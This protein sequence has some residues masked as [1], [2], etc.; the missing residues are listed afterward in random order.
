VKY[1]GEIKSS[2]DLQP[3][4][5]M[6]Q[7]W[8]ELI[9]GPAAPSMLVTPHAVAVHADGVR[10]AVADT[11]SACVHIF[12]LENQQYQRKD[13]VGPHRFQSPTGVAW[14]GDDL[15]VADARVHGLAG[16]SNGRWIGLDQLKRPSGLAFC[17]TNRLLYVADAAAHAIL[18]F[19]RDGRLALQFGGP[20][21][22]AGQFNCPTQL[23]CTQDAVY[24]IDSLNSRVQWMGLD[25][26]PM[27]AFGRP[28]DAAGDLALP[29]GIAIA[30]DG[31]L[32]I[33]DARFENV[34][35]FT[36]EGKLLMALGQEGHGPGEFWLPAGACID[37]RNRLWIA[38]AYNR[39]VQVFQLLP[40][41]L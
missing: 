20:G 4:K 5:S 14:A 28:G 32:W 2:A 39:R 12:N 13:A 16:I 30:S 35:A 3:E 15:W 21:S 10:V 40:D 9:H 26:S 24:V 18:V 22:A 11:S 7:V 19:E 38:D 36:P 17:P 41:A 33:V 34:Q 37:G 23:A 25:G 29:K 8:D 1:V 6:G 27:G 31:H